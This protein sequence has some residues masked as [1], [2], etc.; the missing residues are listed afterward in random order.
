MKSVID[1][2][3]TVFAVH[4]DLQLSEKEPQEVLFCVNQINRL[5]RNATHSY[6]I[7]PLSSASLSAPPHSHSLETP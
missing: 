2:F 5:R 7:N 6:T 3:E 4:D 1:V